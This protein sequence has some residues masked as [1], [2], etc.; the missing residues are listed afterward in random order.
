MDNS[1]LPKLQLNAR[2][3]TILALDLTNRMPGDDQ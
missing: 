1:T 3:M 2:S